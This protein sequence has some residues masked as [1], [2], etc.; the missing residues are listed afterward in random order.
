MFP[1]KRLF[2]ETPKIK[3]SKNQ[4]KEISELKNQ[5]KHNRFSYETVSCGCCNSENKII[6][7]K[8]D[9]YGIPYKSNLC[10]NCGLI[11]TS[12]RFNQKSYI[13]FYDN[14]YRKIYTTTQTQSPEEFFKSQQNQGEKIFNYIKE[15]FKLK[16]DS[17]LEIGCGMGGILYH[18]KKN[19]CKI[20]GVDFGRRYIEQGKNYNLNLKLGGI[21][22][23]HNE[24]FDLIIYSHVFEHIL[25][26]DFELIQIKER[27]NLNGILYIEVPGVLNLKE[28]Y[29]SDLNRYFQN[30]HTYNFT[31]KTLSNILH[32]HGFELI[33]GN[34]KV[35]SIYKIS[36]NNNPKTLNDYNRIIK[37]IKTYEFER[38]TWIFSIKGLKT[39]LVGLLM[40]INLYNVVK[41]IHKQVTSCLL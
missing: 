32:K 35:E 26:L 12:P 19:D 4:I 16:I 20:L 37:K 14:Q 36:S 6:L 15:N 38:K 33:S 8:Y 39:I 31:L 30:A 2:K 17:V 13:A 11:Y 22:D 24:R 9:R 21:N 3:L 27:L 25:D 29:R 28:N 5:I 10:R 7:S 40:Q 1:N 18:F 34:E 23:I 41:K